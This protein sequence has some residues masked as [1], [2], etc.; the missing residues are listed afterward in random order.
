MTIATSE[1][2]VVVERLCNLTDLLRTVAAL[3][4]HPLATLDLRRI[5]NGQR[6]SQ[7]L[8]AALTNVLISSRGPKPAA[9]LYPEAG[10]GAARCL[11]SGL[12]IVP[13]ITGVHD[14][15][16]LQRED[17]QMML[18]ESEATS[19]MFGNHRLFLN[20]HVSG[21]TDWPYAAASLSAVAGRW[22]AGAA[23]PAAER[24]TVIREGVYQLAENLAHAR[25]TKHDASYIFVAVSNESTSI[26]AV[27]LGVGLLGSLSERAPDD[28]RRNRSS[29]LADLF[30]GK[31]T[32]DADRG[33]GL[34]SLVRKAARMGA[35]VE[36]ITC[37]D[38][39]DVPALQYSGAKV[40]EVE[41]IQLQG[42]VVSLICP[43]G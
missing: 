6:C 4:D 3:N 42:T 37:E 31:Y 24:S 17:V 41:G 2:T 28:V 40:T 26:V 43:A 16:P 39:L 34:M 23:R 8:L 10:V 32:Y 12:R 15:S 22:L 7:L 5:G 20:P 9:I 30:G 38:T 11:A 33:R 29:A 1:S 35:V 13:M 14:E 18:G 25:L 27:D 21:V 19:L 36:A